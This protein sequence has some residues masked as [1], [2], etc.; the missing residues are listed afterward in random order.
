MKK[1]LD[2]VVLGLGQ[3][4][5]PQLLGHLG[6]QEVLEGVLDGQRALPVPLLHLVA[7]L[8]PVVELLDLLEVGLVPVPTGRPG[9]GEGL[10]FDFCTV[11][12]ALVTEDVSN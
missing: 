8:V 2:D 3:Q 12:V 5:V 10:G 7:E 4:P 9:A 11:N 6:V 1:H